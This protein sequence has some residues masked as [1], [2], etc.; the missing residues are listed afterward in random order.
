MQANRKVDPSSMTVFLVSRVGRGATK[1]KYINVSSN[2]E[3]NDTPET[4]ILTECVLRP[5]KFSAT[6][7]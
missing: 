6:Q 1:T 2:L 4:K 5:A 3:K 7:V